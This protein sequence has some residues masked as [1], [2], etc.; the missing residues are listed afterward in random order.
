MFA[1][2]KSWL[3]ETFILNELTRAVINTL[4]KLMKKA[5]PDGGKTL[6]GLLVSVMAIAVQMFPEAEPY[7]NPFFLTL[8]ERFGIS[9]GEVAVGSIAYMLIGAAHKLLKALREKIDT[10]DSS[11]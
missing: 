2:L 3:F 9:P 6:I 5:G 1:K 4:D 11:G 10:V 7:L 8:Q